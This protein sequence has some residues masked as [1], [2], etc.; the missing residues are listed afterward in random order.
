ML[1]MNKIYFILLSV[2]FLWRQILAEDV[3]MCKNDEYFDKETGNC[4]KYKSICDISDCSHV[5]PFYISTIPTATNAHYDYRIV[6]LIIGCLV[7]LFL[8]LAFLL[9]YCLLYK[10]HCKI[11]SIQNKNQP[12][13]KE[14]V[15]AID[16][17]HEKERLNTV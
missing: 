5:C 13:L 10:R 3:I 6:G 7:G 8:L 16:D 9:W 15:Q 14:L 17:V 11:R 2:V 4:D 12:E 1:I